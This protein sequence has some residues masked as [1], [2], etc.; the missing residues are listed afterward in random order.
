MDNLENLWWQDIQKQESV[1]QHVS[2]LLDALDRGQKELVFNNGGV[3][4][5]N[6]TLNYDYLEHIEG[7]DVN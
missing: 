5:I 7:I 4:Y 2:D 6:V 1:S 3:D